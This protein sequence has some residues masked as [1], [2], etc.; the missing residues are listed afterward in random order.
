[1]GTKFV[2]VTI[3]Y[4]GEIGGNYNHTKDFHGV[5]AWP[6]ALK[7]VRSIAVHGFEKVLKVGRLAFYPP[8]RVLCLWVEEFESE[9]VADKGAFEVAWPVSSSVESGNQSVPAPMPES[10]STF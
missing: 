9:A 4:E 8:H 2:R 6:E 5:E 3:V 10:I 1:M 7:D